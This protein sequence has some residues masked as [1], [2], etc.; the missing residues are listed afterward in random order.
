[1]NIIVNLCPLIF[2]KY[3]N[4]HLIIPACKSGQIVFL[5]CSFLCQAKAYDKVLVLA[6]TKSL[7]RKAG[8]EYT[9]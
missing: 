1:M 7:L 9:Y 6:Y 3:Q 8:S 5:V 4:R 2:K